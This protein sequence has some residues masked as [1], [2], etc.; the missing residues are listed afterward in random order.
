MEDGEPMAPG[1]SPM[2]QMFKDYH[3]SNRLVQQSQHSCEPVLK[4]EPSPF[5]TPPKIK[6]KEILKMGI[7]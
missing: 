4:V 2:D 5:S 1:F 7:K 3:S 6:K